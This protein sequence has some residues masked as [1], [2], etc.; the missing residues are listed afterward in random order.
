MK[1]KFIPGTKLP[2]NEQPAENSFAVVSSLCIATGGLSLSQVM[3][4]TGLEGSTIQN[5]V[6]RGWVSKP[7]GKK[8]SERQIARILLISVLRDCIQIEQIAKLLSYVNGSV[9]D[10]S[11][12]IIDEGELFNRLCLIIY[13][14]ADKDVFSFDVKAAVKEHLS[15]Y[16]GPLPDSK[17]RLAGALEVMVTAYI[18]SN[19]KRLAENMC[20]DLLETYSEKF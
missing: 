15:D 10:L 7:N 4:I 5:W 16:V 14:M 12:D 17:G 20:K 9:D 6:K 11:D 8:Y 1:L 13:E 19:I 3:G 2:L 18:G